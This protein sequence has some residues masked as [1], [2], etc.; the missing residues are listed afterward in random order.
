MQV[1][2]RRGVG[3]SRHEAVNGASWAA[4]EKREILSR[5]G[6]RRD[7]QAG[8]IARA[9]APFLAIKMARSACWLFGYSRTKVSRLVPKARQ[10][11]TRLREAISPSLPV[12][13]LPATVSHIVSSL[14]SRKIPV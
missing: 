2:M 10:V 14:P 3:N 1:T 12:M 6:K 4:G 8:R 7:G 11:P 13:V 9:M 5:R